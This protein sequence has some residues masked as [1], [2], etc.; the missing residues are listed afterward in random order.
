MQEISLVPE[1]IFKIGNFAVNN[2][3]FATLFVTLIILYIA[4][5]TNRKLSLIPNYFQIVTE[6]MVS[7][8]YTML[9]DTYGNK[10]LAKKHTALIV[11][12]FLFVLISNQFSF[13]PL[14]QS[15]TINGII[16]FKP[17]TAHL[18]QTVA[19]AIIVVGFSHYLG[20][21]LSP[22]KHIGHYIKLE[23]VLKIRKPG[24]IG[25]AFLDIFLGILELMGEVAKIISLSCRLFGNIFA[26]EVMIAV[27]VS[28]SIYTSYIVP[29]PFY[30]LGVFVGGIQALVFAYLATS[31]ISAMAIP[32]ETH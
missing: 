27:L 31:F 28:L 13:I 11:S 30:V 19:L 1:E 32:H 12:L 21:K 7:F 25:M 22:I 2:A 24:D 3:V 5:L 29:V 17:P 15:I 8:F 20:F 18:S 23:S 4:F 16:G 14:V 26:G 9:L 10:K 6:G